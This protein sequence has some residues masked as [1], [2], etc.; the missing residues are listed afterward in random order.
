MSVDNKLKNNNE[1]IYDIIDPQCPNVL[2]QQIY[3]KN[4]IRLCTIKFRGYPLLW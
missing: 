1:L 3:H 2:F 4:S